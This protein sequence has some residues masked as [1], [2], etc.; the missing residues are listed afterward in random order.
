MPGSG[1]RPSQAAMFDKLPVKG[2]QRVRGTTG[3]AA[4]LARTRIPAVSGLA[5]LMS[6]VQRRS[7]DRRRREGRHRQSRSGGRVRLSQA[8]AII[9]RPA[10]FARRESGPGIGHQ[11]W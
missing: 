6:T 8:S 2:T 3:H 7:L 9:R 5:G 10:R 1:D 11:R 4:V